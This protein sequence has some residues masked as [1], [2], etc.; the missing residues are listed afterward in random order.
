MF[1]LLF[2]RQTWFIWDGL[3]Q[4][5]TQ[6]RDAARPPALRGHLALSKTKAPQGLKAVWEGVLEAFPLSIQD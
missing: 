2:W 3:E 5:C 6:Q 4:D 1:G